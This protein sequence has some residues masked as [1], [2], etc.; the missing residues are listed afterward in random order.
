MDENIVFDIK[1]LDKNGQELQPDTSKGEVKVNFE[2]LDLSALE[3]NKEL[4]V[5]HLEDAGSEAKKIEDIRLDAKEASLEVSAEHFSLYVI[6]FINKNKK[7]TYTASIELGEKTNLDVLL[8]G[9]ITLII[10]DVESLNEDIVT[11]S[12]SINK[13]MITALKEGNYLLGADG[14]WDGVSR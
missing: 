3:E 7:L 13:Y 9:L 14:T 8:Q 6:S 12:G 5:Y 10:K 2:S 4:A 11:V 1:V